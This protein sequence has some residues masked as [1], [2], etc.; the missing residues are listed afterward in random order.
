[1]QP[2]QARHRCRREDEQ[3]HRKREE[4]HADDVVEVA[5]VNIGFAT[6]RT[7][8]N[9]REEQRD[10]GNQSEVGER[11]LLPHLLD[12]RLQRVVVRG[13]DAEHHRGRA[14]KWRGLAGVGEDTDS[15]LPHRRARRG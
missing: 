15:S 7:G 2:V 6:P 4:G 13:D 10:E 1:M 5:V 14:P 3:R 9:H 11:A 12:Q 8:Q